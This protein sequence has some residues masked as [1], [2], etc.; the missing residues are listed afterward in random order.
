MIKIVSGNSNKF[1][2]GTFELSAARII[3]TLDTCKLPRDLSEKI[4]HVALDN[5]HDDWRV[6]SSHLL[7][8]MAEPSTQYIALLNRHRK[9]IQTFIE[10]RFEAHLSGKPN[11][12]LN[13]YAKDARFFPT[14]EQEAHAIFA[15]HFDFTLRR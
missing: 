2:G 15:R 3:R 9:D 12:A 7:T 1:N 5:R 8:C 13:R 6:Q 14:T 11:V 10:K 4:Y